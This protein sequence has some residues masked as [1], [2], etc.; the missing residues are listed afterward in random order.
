MSCTWDTEHFLC[1][2]KNTNAMVGC[3]VEGYI[4]FVDLLQVFSKAGAPKS[5]E[6]EGWTTSH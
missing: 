6:K 2:I 1:T 5:C 3:G 4:F